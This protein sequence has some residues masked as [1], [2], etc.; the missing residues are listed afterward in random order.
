VLGLI[1]YPSISVWTLFGTAVSRALRTPGALRAFN[2]LMT[3]LL[4]LS[5]VPVFM[6]V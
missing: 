6:E 1:N 2:G 5:L 3:V 4:L